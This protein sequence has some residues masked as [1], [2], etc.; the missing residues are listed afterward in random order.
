M[1]WQEMTKAAKIDRVN[2]IKMYKAYDSSSWDWHFHDEYEMIYIQDGSANFIIN[3]KETIFDKNTIVFI[4]NMDKHMMT[5]VKEPYVRYVVIIDSSFFEQLVIEPMLCSIFKR[6]TEQFSNGISLTEK[7][8]DFVQHNLDLSLSDYNKAD[9]FYEYYCMSHM[10]KILIYLFRHNRT[11]FPDFM[12]RRKSQAIAPIQKYLDENFAQDI[13]L[14]DLSS[15]FFINK[16]H[17]ARMFKETTGY[18]IKRYI[19]LKRIRKAKELLYLT[20][21]DISQ[22]ATACGYNSTSNFIRAFKDT[23][24][25]TPLCFRKKF[26]SE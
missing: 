23:E 17:L 25:I 9:S 14:D 11:H 5:P 20:E 18:S 3:G 6:C 13:T 12:N 1:N 4:G 24:E 8:S 2:R 21:S 22:I 7:D 26:S 15:T 16:Y 19:T 10:L